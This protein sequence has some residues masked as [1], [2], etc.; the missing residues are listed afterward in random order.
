LEGVAARHGLDK[1]AFGKSAFGQT[2]VWGQRIHHRE[3]PEALADGQADAAIVYF[4][5]ALRYTGI[6]V[7]DMT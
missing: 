4:H 1:V 2:A 5:L 7:K 6:F 3:A